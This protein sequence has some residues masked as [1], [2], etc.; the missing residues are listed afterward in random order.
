[1]P[2]E[3]LA[4]PTSRTCKRCGLPINTRTDR[5]EMQTSD[6]RKYAVGLQ[7]VTCPTTP[8]REALLPLSEAYPSDPVPAATPVFLTMDEAAHLLRVHKNTIANQIKAGRLPAMKMR[9]GRTVLLDQS[10]VL[11]LLEPISPKEMP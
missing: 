5:W 7:H 11:A 9:G 3:K 6:D 2:L 10:D 4:K 1:M 8:E